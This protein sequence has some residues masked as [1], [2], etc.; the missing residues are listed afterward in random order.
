VTGPRLHQNYTE[1][2]IARELTKA[3]ALV[4]G[5]SA[6]NHV[7]LSTMPKKPKVV[8][9]RND[10]KPKLL[11]ADVRPP[12]ARFILR[13]GSTRVAFDYHITATRLP[14]VKKARAGVLATMPNRC[15]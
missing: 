8:P 11:A 15:K 13:I 6:S 9:I 5:S 10:A 3:L 4:L 12:A 14:P 1:K 2:A 7:T